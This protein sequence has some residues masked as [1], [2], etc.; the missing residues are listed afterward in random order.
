MVGK[1]L[2][3]EDREDTVSEAIELVEKNGFECIIVA[4]GS[5]VVNIMT[6]WRKGAVDLAA[7][8][9]DIM[10]FGVDDLSD[11][12]VKNIE[13][14]AGF[15]AGWLIL[16]HYLR[17]TSMPYSNIPV[18]VLSVLEPDESRKTKLTEIR[19]RGGAPIEFIEKFYGVKE[20]LTQLN[21][22]AK[23]LPS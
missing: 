3:I 19:R 18:L 20:W 15:E 2:W 4:S 23:S 1:I 22:W 13:T 14:D 17:C 16:D 9:V 10:L 21:K 5:E 7:I 12:D 11:F 6:D 8:V